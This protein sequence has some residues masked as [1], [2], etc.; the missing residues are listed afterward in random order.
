MKNNRF[1]YHGC[2][3]LLCC[4][5]WASAGIAQVK[6]YAAGKEKIYIHTNHVF[7]TPGETLYFKVYVVN[8]RDQ[9]PSSQSTMVHTDIILPSGNILKTLHLKVKNGYATGSFDFEG[10][11][12]GGIY[13]IRAYTSRMKLEKTDTWFTKEITLQQLIAPRI[14]MQLDF[15]KKGYGPGDTV[16][17]DYTVRNLSDQPIAYHP[18]SFTVSIGGQIIQTQTF[19]TSQA[20]KS[21]L[22]FRL[23]DSLCTSDG[24]LNVTIN[25]DGYTEA[26][27][28]SIPITLQNIDLQFMPEGGTLVQD[29][30]S[31]LAFKAVN[32]YGKPAD[33]KGIIQDQTGKQVATFDS[34]H[35]GMGQCMF[36]PQKGSV[37]TARIISPAGISQQ[38]PLPAASESGV[39]MQLAKKDKQLLIH[40]NATTA[41]TVTLIGSARNVPYYT[42]SL[43]LVKGVQTIT[44]P[45][46]SFPIG[47][48]RFTLST[49]AQVPLAER[50][51]F[52]HAEKNLRLTITPDKKQYL[53]REKVSL[54]LTTTDE[55]GLPV[56]S[57]LSLAV[58]DDKL[59]T[60]ADDKQDHL[61]SWLLMSS[62]LSGKI[63]APQYYF[64]TTKPKASNALDL[65]MLTHGYRYFA[66]TDTNRLT[67]SLLLQ[68]GRPNVLKGILLNT[69]SGRPEPG[70][71]YLIN[72]TSHTFLAQVTTNNTGEFAFPDLTGGEKYALIGRSRHARTKVRIHILQNGTDLY[73][74]PPT[75]TTP[76]TAATP[77]VIDGKQLVSPLYTEE[78]ISSSGSHIVPPPI[79][80]P[81]GTSHLSEVVVISYGTGHR[82]MVS[83]SMSTIR[84]EDVLYVDNLASALQGRV[85]GIQVVN[86]ANQLSTQISLRGATSY[87][88]SSE[89]LFIVDGV[90]M[91]PSWM[92]FHPSNIA[93]ITILK[94]A[95]AVAL[96]GSKAVNGV[97]IITTLQDRTENILLPDNDKYLFTSH[98]VPFKYPAYSATRK[99]YM[100]VYTST[101][102]TER[103]DFRETIYWNPVIQTNRQGT[104]TVEFY[105][106]DAT[107]TFRAIAEGIG[108]NGKAG[109][110]T[111]TYAA[112]NALDIDAKLPPYLTAGDKPQLP[113]VLKNNGIT[114]LPVRLT[115][116]LPANMHTGHFTDSLLLAPGTSRQVLIPVTATAALQDTIRFTVASAVQTTTLTLPVNVAGKG[117]PAHLTLTGNASGQHTFTVSNMVP[118]SMHSQL[119]IFHQPE[120]Q[121]LDGI[122][123]MLREPHG[124]FE[125]VSSTT[126]P[127]LFILKYLQES[128][129]ADTAITARALRYLKNGYD[130]LI[131][132]ETAAKGFEWFG[133]TPPHEALTAYGLMQFTAMQEFMPVDTA[134]LART[135]NFLLSRRDGKGA[136]RLAEGKY[137]FA[138]TPADA[139]HLYIVYALSQAGMGKD[140]LPE[141]ESAV[142]KAKAS[143]DMYLLSL[144]A[145][146]ASNLHRQEDY[147]Q[148]MQQL[149][150]GYQDKTLQLKASLVNASGRSLEIAAKALYALALTKS[151]TPTLPV[152][153]TLITDILAQKSHYG[154][155]STQST[156]LALEALSA[157]SKLATS[158][159]QDLRIQFALNGDTLSAGD[160]LPKTIANGQHVFT[161]QYSQPAATIP[162]SLDLSYQT[163]QPPNSEQA[164]LQLSTSLQASPVKMGSTV[165]MQVAVTN[166]ALARLGM[167][168]AKIGIPAGLSLQPWQLK[169]LTEE[170][171][172]AHYEIFDNYL[173]CYWLG[174]RPEETKT[175]HLDLKADIPGTYR[176]KASNTYLYYMPEHKHWNEGVN[177]T[178]LP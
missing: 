68:A 21:Q 56:P 13:K 47:I 145:L 5:L 88:G 144:A 24:L 87:T 108:Y 67:D 117:F 48:A 26:I 30:T 85:S 170:H 160:T 154:Y 20:G 114:A 156:V 76:T 159:N 45:T 128:G 22:S 50:I 77:L 83:S 74:Y 1:L 99:F 38:Y 80:P 72:E 78:I 44:I 127:N 52:L 164:L 89:P 79:E 59:W 92:R 35:A 169:T 147:R 98:I 165:R 49:A 84:A 94:D 14:L 146:A 104:A 161:V 167:A 37:Y 70:I 34:Y 42:Q 75:A 143:N 129:K 111:A 25:Y 32:E 109:Y 103:D 112:Q 60:L 158:A 27:S 6:D 138:V 3:W 97:I 15:P 81:G 28:R 125:Q 73:N 17:A 171:K 51:V 66:Y 105:N 135:K 173:V 122:A 58:V 96:Y 166:T 134:L 142:K 139:A 40:L 152:I 136:F 123:A 163:F 10:K 23:P 172:V 150:T 39:V 41:Q 141:Y 133:N 113:L 64:D 151:P 93:T 29:M 62:E 101:V 116:T 82:Q 131:A 33:V 2:W 168:V 176:A 175:I 178:V 153:Q 90:P 31:N 121:L 115:V 57:N 63:A 11:V 18:A 126:Y 162:Y 95:N 140:I 118:G 36:T 9:L 107:T 155:G 8:G 43:S 71:V 148:L 137:G 119:R 120:G 174:F 100:P 69:M 102:T 177:V 61:L 53:P 106:S 16:L 46:D 12:A 124:C 86:D 7:F 4:L 55:K 157:Y 149:Q 54:Q 19:Q 130:K 65:M 110:S 132:Y 91:Q